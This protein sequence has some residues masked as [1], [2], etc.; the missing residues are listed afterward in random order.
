[1]GPAKSYMVIQEWTPRVTPS[2]K[3]IRLLKRNT[4]HSSSTPSTKETPSSQPETSRPSSTPE[5]PSLSDQKPSLI[6]SSLES[7]STHPA[8][9]SMPFQTLVSPWMDNTIHS[10]PR[11]TSSK[12]LNSDK[13]NASS[14]SNPWTSQLVS[15]TSL[16]VMSS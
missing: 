13:L 6:K 16:S 5:L 4:G 8:R 15:I 11:T 14:V 2:F 12:L 7:P 10:L 1:M 3:P 9:D